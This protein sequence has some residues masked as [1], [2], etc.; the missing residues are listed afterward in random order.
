[1]IISEIGRGAAGTIRGAI[2]EL[3]IYDRALSA[4]ELAGHAAAR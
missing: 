3:A 1:M 2:D 4:A